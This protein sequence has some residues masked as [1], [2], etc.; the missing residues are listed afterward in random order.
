MPRDQRRLSELAQAT[1]LAVTILLQYFDLVLP[2]NP[3]T[4]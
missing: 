1:K 4:G 2:Q 3:T